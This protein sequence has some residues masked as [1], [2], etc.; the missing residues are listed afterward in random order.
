[1]Q[2]MIISKTS[3]VQALTCHRKLWQL[4]WD[5]DSAGPRS[6]IDQL[7]M[8]FGIRF[9]EIVH[10]LYPDAVLID[11]NVGNLKK[12][13]ED[14]RKAIEEG[15]EVILE[16]T[17]RHEQCRV[18]SDV[19][20]KQPDGSWHLI[21]VKS[22]TKVKDEH[23]PDLAYQKWVVEKCGYP[24][25]KCDVM[26]AD[27][28][29]TWPDKPS[30]FQSEDVTEQVDAY[31]PG[32]PERLSAM[33]EIAS[34]RSSRPK[35]EDWYSKECHNCEFKKTVCWKDINEPTIYDVVHVSKIAPLKVQDVFYVKAIPPDF[36]LSK[37]DRGH[38]DCMQAKCVKINKT[39]IQSMLDEL[40]YPIYFLDFESASV[41]VPLFDGNH[42]W[43]KLPFQYSLHIL[44][45]NGDLRH[46]EYLHEENSDPSQRVAKRLVKDI[47]ET[48]SVV[49]YYKSMEFGVL[50]RLAEIFA[51]HADA[52]NSMNARIW[53]LEVIF[54][55][56]YRHWK[57]GS[58]SSIKVVLPV[59]VPGLSYQEEAISEGGQATLSWIKMLESDDMIERQQ[60]AD[61]LRSY[62][63]LDT[64][65]MVELLKHVRGVI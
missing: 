58:K 29:G 61:E 17:F 56:H 15:T 1:M 28:T 52:L 4:L 6:G 5:R 25:S 54:R 7:R 23:I 27:K 47:G 9:G 44:E 8:E 26:F 57:F 18:L 48:G 42:P 40:A 50:K 34:S 60:I 20:E 46:V 33:L 11:I 30:I 19:I 45:E 35:A 10:C 13:E 24:V 3:F 63:K 36:P 37:T 12:A 39:A 16:G 21:E 32:V 64:L 14:T 62:C 31:V 49:V 38:V 55:R 41:A 65:A 51:Q 43:E 59:L 2:P 53:D 22:S